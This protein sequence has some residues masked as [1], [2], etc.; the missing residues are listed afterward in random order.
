[1]PVLYGIFA[2]ATR[3]SRHVKSKLIITLALVFA[4]IGDIVLLNDKDASNF[5][6]GLIAFL[7][8]HIAYIIF[9]YRIKPFFKKGLKLIIIAAILMAAFKGWLMYLLWPLLTLQGFEIPA[10]T[11]SVVLGIMVVTAMNTANGKRM[12]KLSYLYF[13]PGAL[14][15][16]L[17]DS[18][19]SIN[20]FYA[21]QSVNEIFIMLSYACAQYLIISGAIKVIRK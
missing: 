9:F 18:L 12:R 1:M 21:V 13:I 8:A 11:Y 20:K 17:S 7:F 2:S 15:F 10:L 19:L 3:D 16:L 6:L 4:F 5:T 14:L